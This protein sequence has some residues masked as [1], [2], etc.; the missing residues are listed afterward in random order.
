MK[1]LSN[2]KQNTS[3]DGFLVSK[4]PL[5]VTDAS[6][7]R[8]RYLF[9]API[10]KHINATVTTVAK[11]ITATLTKA[12]SVDRVRTIAF[13]SMGTGVAGL[14]PTKLAPKILRIVA[15]HLER[16]SKL[17]KVIFAFIDEVTYQAYISAYQALLRETFVSYEVLID[18]S[19]KSVTIGGELE[20]SIRLGQPGSSGKEAYVFQLP[21]S[22]AVGSEL[23]IFLTAPG[24]KFNGDNT[25]SLL[26]DSD[27]SQIAQTAHF[28]LT[29]LRPGATKIKAELYCGESFKDSIEIEV[30]VDS[31][32]GTELRPLIAAR[33]ATETSW[34]PLGDKQLNSTITS[35]AASDEQVWIGTH[36]GLLR[37]GKEG[38]RLHL[39]DTPPDVIGLPSPEHSPV[40]FSN[41]AQALSV[42]QLQGR[43]ILWIG[44]VRGLYRLDLFSEA[45]RRYGQ[46][47]TQDI[48]AIT[49]STDQKT[50]W[51]ASWSSGLHGL[52][53]KNELQ[54]APDIS[55]PILALATKNAQ[56]WTVGLNGLYHYKDSVWVQVISSKE[57]PVRGWLQAVVQGVTDHVWL[58]TSAGL[59]VYKPDT[60]Q[61]TPV[62]GV[63][64]SADVRSRSDSFGVSLLAI[65][66]GESELLWVGTSQGLY[67]GNSSNWESVSE[68]EN[69]TITALVWDSN[70][71]SLWVGTDRGLFRLLAVGNSPKVANEF[72]IHNSGLGANRVTALTISTGEDGE[73]KLWVGTPCGLSCYAY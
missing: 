8:A 68:L 42:Q 26:L 37:G 53:Q 47:G 52:T 59:L 60:K 50:V 48:R 65:G 35:L 30:Q 44:T 54:T 56:Y 67:V 2:L 58:G 40:T 9:H 4:I 18:T 28:H 43:S 10:D 51:V 16:G 39:T 20:V 6:S 29:A 11:A 12:E 69:R 15:S 7:L 71:S 19:A 5:I 64:G 13:P 27:T 72:H 61:L 63:L 33:S 25:T 31:F 21:Q 1:N 70:A 38:M 62:S 32:N 55:E 14:N 66:W 3:N 17:E 36:D 24:F 22:E 46:L 57:L 41:L 49:T 23:N 34:T 45:W 73:T